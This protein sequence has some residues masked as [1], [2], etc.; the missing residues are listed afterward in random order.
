MP[1][2]LGPGPVFIHE[3]IAATRRWQ[4]YA[5]RALFVCGLL[6]SL[7]VAWQWMT[8]DRVGP[9][10]T[11]AIRKLAALGQSFYLAIAT[12]QIAL[13]LVVAPAATAG[14]ICLD[15]SRGT[16]THMMVT[17]L[18]DSEI[19]LGK[20]AARLLPVFALV[21]ATTP[22]LALAG[23]LGGI[24]LEAIVT[25]TVITLAL[26]VFC[27]T[28][29]LAFSVRATRTHEV[30]MAVYTIEA[31]WVLGP[32]VWVLLTAFAVSRSV[33][34]WMLAVN[35]FVLA[36]APYLLS[37][38][39]GHRGTYPRRRWRARGL[40]RAHRVCRPEA[41]VGGLRAISVAVAPRPVVRAGSWRSARG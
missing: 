39:R 31:F 41:P 26:A 30:L 4:L 25:L 9:S 18:A 20:L 15:R 5:A 29:A 27:S 12:A 21:A 14:S 11:V 17:D 6:C 33:P 3:S 22:V 38:I 13:V 34:V 2:N 10:G 36:W 23:L 40:G 7:A 28:L 16:L 19:V 32:V 35:P 37:E 8:P 1:L 24:V